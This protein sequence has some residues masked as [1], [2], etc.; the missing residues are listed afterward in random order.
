MT[1]RLNRFFTPFRKPDSGTANVTRQGGRVAP[2][3]RMRATGGAAG[4]ASASPALRSNLPLAGLSVRGR[5]VLRRSPILQIA[6]IF[7]F[8][9]LGEAIVRFAGIPVPGGIIGMVIV[10]ALLA[11]RRI[12]LHSMRQGAQWYLAEMLLFFIPAVLALLNHH[13]LFGLLGVKVLLV[14][15]GSTASVIAVTALV[16]DL[17]MRFRGRHGLV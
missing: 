17:F 8:W 11:S 5:Y 10:F 1:H 4:V 9:L 14:I 12:S 13:E 16:M 15:L 3:S 7:A 2:V 6:A